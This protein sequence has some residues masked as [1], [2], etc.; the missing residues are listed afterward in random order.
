MSVQATGQSEGNDF[1]SR[2]K[3]RERFGEHFARLSLLQ[4]FFCF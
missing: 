2:E 4:T 1:G 3:E